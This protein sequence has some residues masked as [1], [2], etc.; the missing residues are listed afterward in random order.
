MATIAF[1]KAVRLAQVGRSGTLARRDEAMLPFLGDHAEAGA[2]L[3]LDT[4]IY[5][6]QMQGRLPSVVEHLV[7]LRTV[8]HTTVAVTE[9]MHAVGRLDPAHPETANVVAQMR[10][11]VTAIREHRLREPDADVQARAAV[12]SG[13]LCRLQGYAKDDRFRALHDAMIY[14]QALKLGLT[15]LTRNVRDFD[16]LLQLMPEGRVL[17]YRQEA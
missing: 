6:D 10:A 15:V 12:L 14:F 1:E 5:I 11:Q 3:L 7:G 13:V 17:L 16:F 9:L 2:S 8:F 4:T